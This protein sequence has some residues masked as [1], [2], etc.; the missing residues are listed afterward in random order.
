MF[1]MNTFLTRSIERVHALA[2]IS[3]SALCCHSNETRAPTANPPRSPRLDRTPRTIPR[4]YIRSVQYSVRMRR[5]TDRQTHTQT[6]VTSIHISRLCLTRN[7]VNKIGSCN[8]YSI[9][10]SKNSYESNTLFN[11]QLLSWSA[12]SSTTGKNNSPSTVSFFN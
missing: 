9:H 3:R 7:A 4:G 2:D 10:A 1:C 6:A 5:G 11:V 8:L 12:D